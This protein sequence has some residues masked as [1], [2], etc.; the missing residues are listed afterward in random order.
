MIVD[1]YGGANIKLELNLPSPQPEE[2]ML[3]KNSL[4]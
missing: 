2:S 4:P 1:P 3:I